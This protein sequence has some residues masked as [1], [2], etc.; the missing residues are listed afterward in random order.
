MQGS[1]RLN[2]KSKDRK[3]WEN[4]RITDLLDKTPWHTI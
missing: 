3:A 4:H 2:E 1:N